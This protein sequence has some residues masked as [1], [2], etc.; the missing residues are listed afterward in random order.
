R[1]HD[2]CAARASGR[3]H[4]RNHRRSSL[5]MASVSKI[6]KLVSITLGII[7]VTASL[8]ARTA[9]QPASETAHNPQ[10]I[11]SLVPATTEMLFVMGA[12]GRIAGVS[13]YDRFPPEVTKLPTIG[14]LIDPNVE[15]LISLRPDLVI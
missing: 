5:F 6:L 14:G 13:D 15:R 1:A 11:I 8:K 4:H 2:H 12:G 7:C 9:N 10:R 3:Y